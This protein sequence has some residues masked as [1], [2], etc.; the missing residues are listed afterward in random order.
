MI[1]AR[2]RAAAAPEPPAACWLPPELRAAIDAMPGGAT[3]YRKRYD[4]D[5]Q[6]LE[7][8]FE[9][10][11]P[12]ALAH[13]V[14][15]LRRRRREVLARR[16]VRDIIEVLDRA[17][18]RWLDPAYPPRATAIPDI[19]FITGFS[20]EMVGHAIDEEQ[21]SSRGPHLAL[22]LASELGD[23]EFLDGFR[24][25]PR[26]GGLTRA[27]GPG[28]V[29]AIFSSN[30]PALPHLEIMRSF[31]VKAACLGRVSAGEPVFLRR[32]A[33]TLHELDPELASCLAI[34]YWER[35]DDELEAQFLRS[36]DYL[37]AYGGDAQIQ[38]LMAIR[39]PALDATWHGHR[40]GFTY[41]TREALAAGQDV[42][43]LARAI[44]YDFAI[45]DGFACL[46]PQAVLVED[47]GATTP[48]ELARLCSEAMARWVRELPPRRL[49]LA[50]AA[51]KQAFAQL[52]MM[53]DAIEVIGAPPD[54]SYLVTI[55]AMQRFEPSG[56]DRYLRVVP[57]AG[58]AELDRLIA[59][60]PRQHL[61][62]AA[63]AAGTAAARHHELRELLASWGVT[64]VV[65]PGIMGRP[66]MMWHHDGV[67]CVGRMVTWCDHELVVPELLL[68][69]DPEAL[70]AEAERD[71][72]A[73]LGA[74]LR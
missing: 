29:G 10:L 63:I 60:L 67:A 24:P 13:V 35:G 59:P 50:A 23:P 68:G 20:P 26:T 6:H 57:V 65:P 36:V 62:C 64:R 11:S 3:P 17:A 45:F 61:Q 66:S 16:S 31:L 12:D 47:G 46:C 5:D 54:G 18:T 49:D 22:A 58:P 27:Y 2:I 15:F 56:G 72:S 39:P 37:V 51:R 33:E 41:V 38:R 14:G 55:E 7:V 32:Y 74:A 52:C 73:M 8:V 28:L 4:H 30:I 19:A 25:N 44:A 21:A 69:R 48:A 9:R 1:A 40:L 42:R 43:R 34:V 71:P 70:I 53:S